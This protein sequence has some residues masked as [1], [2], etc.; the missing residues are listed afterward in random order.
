M[1]RKRALRNTSCFMVLLSNTEDPVRPPP[2]EVQKGKG[3][4]LN[5]SAMNIWLSVKIDIYH[6]DLWK[7]C[8]PQMY[9]VF[10]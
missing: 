1:S 5:V 7:E 4:L 10:R 3:K 9:I 6:N 8:I 2:D